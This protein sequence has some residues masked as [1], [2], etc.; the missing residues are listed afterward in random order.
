MSFYYSVSE[1]V[2]KTDK[3]M[4][5][6]VISTEVSDSERSGEI[7]NRKDFSTACLMRFMYVEVTRIER[8]EQNYSVGI[9][10]QNC[11]MCPAVDQ[12]DDD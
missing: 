6:S 1:F 4:P 5:S 3:I 9:F 11:G 7:Y 2:H 8:S 10:V 12:S